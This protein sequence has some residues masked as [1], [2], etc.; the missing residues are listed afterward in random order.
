MKSKRYQTRWP[1]GILPLLLLFILSKLHA[2]SAW[3]TFSGTSG[4][5][6]MT[7]IMNGPLAIITAASGSTT[8]FIPTRRNTWTSGPYNRVPINDPQVNANGDPNNATS[9]DITFP[10]GANTSD[11]L[12][13][14]NDMTPD[15]S[16]GVT[17][18]LTAYPQSGANLDLRTWTTDLG[19]LGGGCTNGVR[20]VNNLNGNAFQM[21]LAPAPNSGTCVSSSA[22]LIIRIPQANVRLIQIRKVQNLNDATTLAIGRVCRVPS[23]SK[24]PVSQASCNA[25]NNGLQYSVIAGGTGLSYDWQYSDNNGASFTSLSCCPNS[26]PGYNTATL[27]TNGTESNGR[28]YRVVVSNLCGTVTSNSAT[29]TLDTAPTITAQP[30]APTVCSGNSA[31]YSVTASGTDL[32]YLWQYSD[33]G[34]NYASLAPFASTYP[35]YN[36]DTLTARVNGGRRT[37]RVIVTNSCGLSVISNAVGATVIAPLSTPTLA[38]ATQPTCKVATGTFTISNYNAASTYTI[39]PA[40]GVTRNGAM[41]TAPVGTYTVTVMYNGCTATS[42]P[43]TFSTPTCVAVSGAVFNDANGLTDNTVSGTSVNGPTLPVY[44]SLV[45]AGN[46][47]ATVPVNVNGAYSFT[48]VDG[49][50]GYS[51][52]LTTNLAG[53]TTPSLPANWTNTGEYNGATAGDDGTPDG[54]LPVTVGG[55]SVTDANFGIEQLP[56]AGS[57]T[58]TVANAGG[59]SSMSVPVN[60][61]TNTTPSSDPSPGNVISIRIT[62]F[63][64][65]TTSLTIN[66]TVYIPSSP[67]FTGATPTGV[68]VPT[69]GSGNPTVAVLVDPTNDASLVSIPFKA[70]DNAGMAST[71][72]GTAVINSSAVSVPDLTPISYARPSTVYNTTTITVVVDVVELLGV[73]TN[74]LITVRVTKDAKLPLSFDPAAT[75]VNGRSVQ[76]NLWTF[77]ATANPN[78]YMLTTTSVVAAGDKLTFGFTGQLIPGATTGALTVSSVIIGGSGGEARVNNNVDA[79]KMDY[80]QQ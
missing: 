31:T 67:E 51:I 26:Y 44:A 33:D 47:I 36:A 73:A 35:G 38:A 76:N 19:Q 66:G 58:N 50:G 70:I 46:L 37:Y 49:Y 68:V 7:A 30:T 6:S 18:S 63:P 23:I 29:F 20:V 53:S 54:I 55:V 40:T 56:V 39:S 75:R 24:Q 28:R 14:L 42:S 32:T 11:L 5:T 3:A 60:T 17:Y 71:N 48:S 59:T 80:F 8:T 74:G 65:N 52:V 25:T 27:T 12:L 4:G 69:D 72:T 57:G 10:T 64:S 13:V 15:A 43:I 79:D 61:F 78:Y 16:G 1:L 2:Q 62:G 45:Q 22:A 41:V 77:N 9:Y 34:T 21:G